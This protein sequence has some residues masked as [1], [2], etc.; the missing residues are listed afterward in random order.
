[1]SQYKT[2][3]GVQISFDNKKENI[4][5]D[6]LVALILSIQSGDIFAGFHVS[7]PL[8]VISSIIQVGAVREEELIAS[9]AFAAGVEIQGEKQIDLPVFF[10]ALGKKAHDY[11]QR[12]HQEFHL[13]FPLNLRRG[14]IP[15]ERIEVNRES[16]EVISW[17]ETRGRYDIPNL[18]AMIH[19]SIHFQH[20][21]EYWSDQ[22]SALL[23]KIYCRSAE[24]AFRKGEK[25][26][27]NF[28]SSI[29]Y[30]LDTSITIHLAG[31]SPYAKVVPSVGYG[32][33]LPT[34]DLDCPYIDREFLN[35]QHLCSDEF[36]ADKLRAIL[37]LTRSERKID[38]RFMQALRLHSDG[39]KTTNW[40]ASFLSFWRVL[41]ILAFGERTDYDMNDVVKR[42]CVL[43]KANSKTKDFLNLCAS[44][45]NSLVHR[46]V[47]SS[48]GQ[49]L[50]LTIKI[51]S[52]LC[53]S[54]F[55]KLLQEYRT[56]QMIEKYF[57]IVDFTTEQ[58]TEQRT[59]IENILKE[60][61]L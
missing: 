19:D 61:N 1:M 16:F 58:L 13:V 24:E 39:L 11:L 34:G 31:N 25:A 40:D 33:F 57:E 27:D 46:G 35:Y 4:I 55:E 42:T 3:S 20:H 21:Q 8:L 43:L 47:F 56:E 17:E 7:P 22:G 36:N 48:E 59:V 28:L 29:N 6:N 45:R 37:E 50:V 5:K 2:L 23:L 44:R 54:R 12:P 10:E 14:K 26:Y 41:E 9:L 52:K 51:F 38:Q 49:P 30:I 53:L 18:Q 32:V 15:F 60:R